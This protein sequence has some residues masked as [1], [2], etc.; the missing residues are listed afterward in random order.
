M[1]GPFSDDSAVQLVKE[2]ADIAEVVGEHV[3]LSRAGANLKGLCP[4]H[5]E[6]T[7][8]FHVS[9]AKQIYKCYVAEREGM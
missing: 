2:R 9:P 3:S 8:S 6:K 1:K 7:P 4:F 5:V